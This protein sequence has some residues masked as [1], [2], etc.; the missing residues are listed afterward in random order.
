MIDMLG[1]DQRF[2]AVRAISLNAGVE[3]AN[4]LFV[5]GKLMGAGHVFSPRF[6]LQ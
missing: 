1:R 2:E 4:D 3:L 5:Q 6:R